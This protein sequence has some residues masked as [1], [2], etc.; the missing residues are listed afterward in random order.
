MF[1][2]YYVHLSLL[3]I[4]G[5]FGA[6]LDGVGINAIIPLFSFL[7]GQNSPESLNSISSI[8]ESFFVVLHI[9]FTFR[10][11][12]VFIGGIFLMRAA[13]LLWFAYVRARVTASFTFR[14]MNRLLHDTIH[15]RWKYLFAHKPGFL[16]NTLYWDIN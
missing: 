16:Q 8:I 6:V 15:A 13:V 3:V 12:L 1:G 11:L 14:E 4:L 9:P 10:Y 2:E 7:L 5:I